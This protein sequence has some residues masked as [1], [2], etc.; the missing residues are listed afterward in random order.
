MSANT[1]NTTTSRSAHSEISLRTPTESLRIKAPNY[2]RERSAGEIIRE[3]LRIYKLHCFVI[4]IV[5]VPVTVIAKLT[6][7]VLVFSHDQ[8]RIVLA[9]RILNWIIAYIAALHLTVVISHIYLGYD[10]KLRM[11]LKRSVSLLGKAFITVLLVLLL[12]PLYPWLMFSLQVV[13]IE[14]VWGFKALRRSWELGR[15]YRLRNFFIYVWPFTLYVVVYM[16]INV[17]FLY[18]SL[19][20]PSFRWWEL[21]FSIA[22]DFTL[23][24][25]APVLIIV[26]VLL[27]YDMR[28]RNEAYDISSLAEDLRI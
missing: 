7:D 1:A 3:G 17:L 12:F 16:A 27:Y 10:V 5:Y 23:S 19:A 6:T 4:F 24:L 26:A 25:I 2:I 9:A 11:A 8:T 15:Y 18:L 22:K 21:L 14:G 28:I 13:M 20:T